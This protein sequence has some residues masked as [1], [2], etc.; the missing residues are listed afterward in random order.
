VRRAE[1]GVALLEAMVALAILASAGTMLVAA[2]GA[3]LRSEREARDRELT[4]RAADRVLPAATLLTRRD[5][6]QRL[7]SHAAGEFVLEV[8]R[9]EPALYRI[10]ISAASAPGRE[11]LVTVVDR[12]LP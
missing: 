9:P 3:G 2:V 1:Q 6:D 11:L 5:L 10:G 8:E 4:L 12:D 7:G